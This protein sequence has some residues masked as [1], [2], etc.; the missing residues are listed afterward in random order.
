LEVTLYLNQPVTLTYSIPHHLFVTLALCRYLVI[1]GW[2]VPS[3]V[4]VLE[5]HSIVVFKTRCAYTFV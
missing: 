3:S 4:T 2:Q 5:S 1:V